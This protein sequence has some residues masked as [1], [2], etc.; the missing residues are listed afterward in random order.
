MNRF[1]EKLGEVRVELR[2]QKLEILQV[3]LGKLC[4]LACVHCHMEAGPTKTRENMNRETAE[5]VVRFMDPAQIKTL[6][7]TGGAPEL[8]PN[9]RYLV[10]EAKQRGIHVIDR[11]NL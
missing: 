11:C 6:D 7:L 8:N 10:E 9:F 5:A 1:E 2:K 4:N 3:N